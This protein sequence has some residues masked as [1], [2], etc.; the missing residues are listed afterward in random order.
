MLGCAGTKYG[1]T[2]TGLQPVLANG[3]FP[4]EAVCVAW[5]TPDDHKLANFWELERV[6]ASGKRAGQASG[7]TAAKKQKSGSR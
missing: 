4:W 6:P 7:G 1:G 3:L 2:I 5:D